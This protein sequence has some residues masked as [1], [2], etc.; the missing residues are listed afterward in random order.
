MDVEEGGGGEEDF[1]YKILSSITP[2]NLYH[3]KVSNGVFLFVT[4]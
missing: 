1:D 4:Y 2:Y 3:E